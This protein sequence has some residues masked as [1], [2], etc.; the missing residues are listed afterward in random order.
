MNSCENGSLIIGITKD[1]ENSFARCG[2]GPGLFTKSVLCF[3]F[4]STIYYD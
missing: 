1:P 2:V 4:A 3:G